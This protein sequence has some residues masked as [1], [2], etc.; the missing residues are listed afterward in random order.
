MSLFNLKVCKPTN[1]LYTNELAP[2]SFINATACCIKRISIRNEKCPVT[3]MNACTK[4][5]LIGNNVWENFFIF[6]RIYIPDNDKFLLI[7]TVRLK[8]RGTICKEI[9]LFRSI[10]VWR[11]LQGIPVQIEDLDQSEV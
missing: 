3:R 2:C 11:V 4:P 10:P 1:A 8:Y 7:T 5:Y 9:E 6:Q